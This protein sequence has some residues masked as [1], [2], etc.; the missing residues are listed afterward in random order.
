MVTLA[1]APHEEKEEEPEDGVEESPETLE[2]EPQPGEGE[3]PAPQPA[4][5]E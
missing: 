2:T 5:E 1:R 4:G 3:A